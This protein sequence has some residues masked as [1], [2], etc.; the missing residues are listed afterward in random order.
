MLKKQ[1]LW[2]Y[3]FRKITTSALSG[4][5][6]AI[7]SRFLGESLTSRSI[8]TE[9]GGTNFE[10]VSRQVTDYQLTDFKITES[11]LHKYTLIT[12]CLLILILNTLL[13]QR[14]QYFRCKNVL[15]KSYFEN[16]LMI[17]RMLYVFASLYY[18]VVARF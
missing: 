4:R 8:R 18:F 9:S 10:K 14:L 16:T 5:R 1:K 6:K 3:L 7:C 2:S 11:I 12:H 13:V 17:M 15:F